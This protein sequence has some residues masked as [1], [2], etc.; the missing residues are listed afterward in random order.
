MTVLKALIYIRGYRR[1]WRSHAQVRLL[2]HRSHPLVPGSVSESVAG[3]PCVASQCHSHGAGCSD[4]GE[5]AA[6][7]LVLRSDHRDGI[8]M[9][10]MNVLRVV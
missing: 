4:I 2:R 8:S 9:A 5:S 6:R 10:R 1:P 3:S 7:H